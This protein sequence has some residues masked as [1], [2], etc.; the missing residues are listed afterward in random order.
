MQVVGVGP[1]LVV[2]L[3]VIRSRQVWPRIH[4]QQHMLGV[5]HVG[6]CRVCCSSVVVDVA[7]SG[8]VGA[9]VLPQQHLLRLG[10]GHQ[11]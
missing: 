3:Q 11:L 2:L 8:E 10:S 4:P 9:R 5:H 7:E 6:C 1:V